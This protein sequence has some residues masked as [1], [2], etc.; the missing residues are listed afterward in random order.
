MSAG[1]RHCD[2]GRNPAVHASG[3]AMVS[4]NPPTARPVGLLV[5]P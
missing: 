5:T 4:V 2:S 1:E 3:S